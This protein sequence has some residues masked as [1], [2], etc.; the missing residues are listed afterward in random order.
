MG[1][2]S[3]PAGGP[4]SRRVRDKINKESSLSEAD[5]FFYNIIASKHCPVKDPR[6]LMY[7]YTLQEVFIMS[8]FSTMMD[9]LEEAQ[10]KDEELKNK[11]T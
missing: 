6:T 8:E 3:S 9:D 10:Y 5:W 11:N 7:N 1:T 4:N 2:G